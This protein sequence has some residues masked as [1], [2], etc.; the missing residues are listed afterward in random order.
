MGPAISFKGKTMTEPW[1]KHVEA[2]PDKIYIISRFTDKGIKTPDE[3]HEITWAQANK[4]IMDFTKGLWE[5][6]F[7]EH[8]KL[9]VMGPNRPRWIFSCSAALSSRSVI[10]PIYPTSKQDDV[11]WILSDSEVKFVLCGS[12]EHAEKV[13]KAKPELELLEKIILMDQPPKDCDDF[14]ISFEDVVEKGKNSSISDDDIKKRA[15]ETEED[16]LAAII[17]TSGTTGRPK[18]V[19]LTHKNFVAQRPLEDD[20]EFE[21]N[22]VFMAHLPMCHSFGFSSD[23]LSANNIGATLFVCRQ[24]RNNGDE[25]K[26]G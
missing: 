12:M 24:P 1:F 16:D 11:W 7:K 20:F 5:M 15:K 2:H 9:A 8:D 26:F 10:V 17:Y 14:I 25:E 4:T 3:L 18:G 21:D 13:L 22:E 6:G 23:F 19:E